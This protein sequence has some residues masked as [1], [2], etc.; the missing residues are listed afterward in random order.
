[1]DTNTSLSIAPEKEK[2]ASSDV[3]KARPGSGSITAEIMKFYAFRAD[4]MKNKVDLLAAEI[5]QRT[6]KM[7]LINDIIAEINNLT[8]DKHGLDISKNPDLLE[9]L[10]IAKE[11]G[12]KVKDGKTKLNPLERD[13]LIENLHLAADSWDKENRHQTQKLEIHVKTLDRILM[14]LKDTEKKEDQP[15]R[16]SIA[17]ISGG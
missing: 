1:M 17:G 7:R 6:D 15:K 4:E 3:S 12:V 13:R 2:V 9:K 14:L 8:D 11:L 16:R 5:N 10:L